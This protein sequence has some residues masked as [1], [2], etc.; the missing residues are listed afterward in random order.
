LYAN[1]IHVNI[2]I[3]DINWFFCWADKYKIS[4]TCQKIHHN[5]LQGFPGIVSFVPINKAP[6][7]WKIFTVFV[8]NFNFS[9]SFKLGHTSMIMWLDN[10]NIAT[11]F[12]DLDV[13][14]FCCFLF[15]LVY[16]ASSSLPSSSHWSPE[17]N[18]LI[19]YRSDANVLS[20]LKN[21]PSCEFI[22]EVIL[23]M[24]IV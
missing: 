5:G 23:K 24:N 11:V 18:G 17:F 12:V 1:L 10:R 21:D 2:F 3:T 14:I 22:G 6:L 9:W 4:I 13:S 16:R 20:Y 7:G 19:R 8:E 15:R